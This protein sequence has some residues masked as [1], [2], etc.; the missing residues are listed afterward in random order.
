MSRVP[1]YSCNI[2]CYARTVLL[3]A[4]LAI[5]VTHFAANGLTQGLALEFLLSA[6]GVQ[7]LP[8]TVVMTGTVD[9]EGKTDSF[10][11]FANKDEQLRIEY[12]KSGKDTV[13]M[14]QKMS[15]HD[16]GEK[17]TY[18]STPPGFAQLDITGLF[19]VEQLRNRPVAV[20]ST[21]EWTV[22]QGTKLQR[23]H[24]T[25]DRKEMQR[26]TIPVQDALDLYVNESG[27]LTAISRSFYQGRAEAY[28][29]AFTFSDYRKSDNTLL[30]Y[31]IDVY[32]KGI[33]RQTY[34]IET[35]QFDVPQDKSLFNAWRPK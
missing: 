3:A 1:R 8:S 18:D 14:R 24:V 16:D 28:T 15:F 29:L 17:L 4:T 22:V 33:R 32:I 30:P 7:S 23:Y 19:L 10:R 21:K 31:Q 6:H 34:K 13:V 25:N 5:I 20:D 9:R 35:Y 26:G 11:L 12:G 27:L 2:D